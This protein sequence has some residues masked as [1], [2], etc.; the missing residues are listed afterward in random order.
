[1]AQRRRK[2]RYAVVGLGGIAQVA[3]LPAFQHAQNSE[4]AALVSGDVQKQSQSYCINAARYLFQDEPNEVAAF[5]SRNADSR[6]K[7]IDEMTAAVMRFT[8]DRLA[9]FT[10]S[11]G[12]DPV[13]NYILAGT[14][15]S[16]RVEPAY[17]YQTEIRHYLTRKEKTKERVFAKRDQFAA[18]LV[19][20]SDCVLKDREPEPSGE[21]GLADVRIIRALRKSAAL[22]TPVEVVSMSRSQRPGPKL[23][24]ERP[25]LEKPPKLV[26]AKTASGES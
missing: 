20:F 14:K 18:E 11:F 3:V 9:S 21:E 13:S 15:G 7:E 22:N 2:I 5:S 6:F 4:L 24:I 26:R 23:E 17:E 19:Y 12:A 25:P 1:M 16:L 8:G 10:S